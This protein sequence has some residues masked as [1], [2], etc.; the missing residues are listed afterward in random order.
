MTVTAPVGSVEHADLH[1]RDTL[2]A[3]AG[4]CH[5][6]VVRLVVEDFADAET[7]AALGIDDPFELTGL[8][9]GVPV[10]GVLDAFSYTVGNRALGNADNAACLELMGQFDFVCAKPCRVVLAN[11]GAHAQ[12]N[13]QSVWCGQVIC[14]QEGD[15]L[16]T[17][18]PGLGFWNPMTVTRPPCSGLYSLYS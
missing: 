7:L 17:Q 18:P 4:L 8:Y 11:R 1:V 3:G 2:D 13:N 10:G 15:V 6:E 14:L 9:E 5:P 16:R 12:L